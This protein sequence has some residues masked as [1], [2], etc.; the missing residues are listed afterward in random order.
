M[1]LCYCF[2]CATGPVLLQLHLSCRA[3][4]QLLHV[5]GGEPIYVYIYYYC[6]YDYCILCCHVYDCEQDSPELLKHSAAAGSIARSST[7]HSVSTELS[8]PHEA[9]QQAKLLY[10]TQSYAARLW[11]MNREE[12]KQ[13]VARCNRRNALCGVP[14][15]IGVSG[16]KEELVECLLH[17]AIADC[18]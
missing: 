14:V 12:L 11:G 3:A 6:C 7:A 15:K 18:D 2:Y 13:E 5:G 8:D 16:T 4:L 1:Y 17:E 10:T 9:A